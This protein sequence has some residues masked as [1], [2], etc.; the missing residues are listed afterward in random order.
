MARTLVERAQQL[1][2][3]GVAVDRAIDELLELSG[4]DRLELSAAFALA[5]RAGG[6]SSIHDLDPIDTKTPQRCGPTL[7]ATVPHARRVVIG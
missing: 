6:R 1:C 4:R 2:D 3:S 5:V 7:N